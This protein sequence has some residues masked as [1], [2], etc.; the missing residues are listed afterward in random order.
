MIITLCGSA[1]FE[2]AFKSWNRFL[3][4][5]GHVVFSLAVYPSDMQHVKNWYTEAEK[6][7]LDLV[8]K[9][10]IRHSAAIFVITRNLME[11]EHFAGIPVDNIIETRYIG[12]STASELAFAR[13]HSKQVFFDDETCFNTGCPDRLRL[14]DPCAA[15]ND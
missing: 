1:R 14:T 2:S 7:V 12:E 5:Q 6:T 8:H 13:E 3:T 15:C 11:F 4:L 9:E 10:K